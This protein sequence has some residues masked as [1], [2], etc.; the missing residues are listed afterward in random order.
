[1]NNT[2]IHAFM[3]KHM[4]SD[5]FEYASPFNTSHTVFEALQTHHKKLGPHAQINLLLKEFSIFYEPSIPM[6]TT[7]KQ[8]RDLHEH[9]KKMGKINKDKLFLFVIINALGCHFPQLQLDI[10]GMMD[11]PDFNWAAAIRCIDTKAALVQRCTEVGVALTT[12]ALLGTSGL[13]SKTSGTTIMCSNCKCLHY[14]IEFCIK[15]GGKMA[16]HTLEEAKAAQCAAAGK[17]P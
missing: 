12:V 14:T 1:M 3:L 7:S 6:T 8:L 17:A 10:H 16:G 5:E 4:S 15:P 11:D 9:M 2:A 13:D